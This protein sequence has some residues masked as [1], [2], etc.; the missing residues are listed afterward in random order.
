MCV[1][2]EQNEQTM[3]LWAHMMPGK[4]GPSLLVPAILGGGLR[5]LW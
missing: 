2:K 3:P 1:P 4:H 5:S